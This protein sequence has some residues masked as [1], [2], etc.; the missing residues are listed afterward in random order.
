MWSSVAAP[1]LACFFLSPAPFLPPSLVYAMQLFCTLQTWDL[2]VHGAIYFLGPYSLCS[3]V[4]SP[5]EGHF[6][7]W[8]DPHFFCSQSASPMVDTLD[9]RLAK[10]FPRQDATSLLVS[11]FWPELLYNSSLQSS[12]LYLLY[13]FSLRVGNWSNYHPVA[14]CP[15]PCFLRKGG[16]SCPWEGW[17]WKVVT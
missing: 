5:S 17:S 12:S 14:H 11:S 3:Q 13:A 15:F 8:L 9:S 10:S 7:R 4:F 16:P 2:A 1:L 6:F